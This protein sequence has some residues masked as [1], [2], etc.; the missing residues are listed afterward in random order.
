MEDKSSDSDEERKSGSELE[1]E[2]SYSDV[3]S[4]LGDT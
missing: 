1:D 2:S 3:N 4:N